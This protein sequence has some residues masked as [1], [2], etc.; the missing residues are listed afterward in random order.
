MTRTFRTG[1]LFVA[2][3]LTMLGVVLL[4]PGRESVAVSAPPTIES[5]LTTLT[6]ELATGDSR[7]V[8]RRLESR[9]AANTADP[10]VRTA[11]GLGYLQL[12]RESA[13]PV[14]LSRSRRALDDAV[15]LG[16]SDD[17]VTR[18]GLAQLSATQ[19]RFREAEV[20]AREAVRLAPHNAAALGVLGDALL[21]LGRYGEAFSAYDRAAGQGPSVG[22]YARVARARELLGRPAAARE[23]M[24]LAIE[25]GSAIPEQKAWALTR[26]GNLL[27]DEGSVAEARRAFARALVIQPRFP[28]A[29]AGAA[30]ADVRRTPMRAARSLEALITRVPSAEYAIELGDLYSEL[31]RTRAAG[32]AYERAREFEHRLARSGVRTMLASAGL[33]LELGLHRRSALIRARQAHREAPNVETEAVLAWALVANGHC[34]EARVFSRRALALG[35]RDAGFSFVRGLIERCLGNPAASRWFSEA[36]EIDPTFSPRWAPVAARLAR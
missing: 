6:G 8:V 9:A 28:H 10:V 29:Q 1:L 13:D 20:H 2:A 23:A 26:Y 11:L 30:R 36:L 15:A 18:L 25:A 24:E 19:H 4:G 22:A 21:E 12:F 7:R 5:E 35:T 17:A 31:G 3:L 16:R 27:L 32:R 14:W 33:D 34:R